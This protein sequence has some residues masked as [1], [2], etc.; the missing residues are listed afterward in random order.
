MNEQRGVKVA[1]R[2]LPVAKYRVSGDSCAAT[3]VQFR[4]Q[5]Q[6]IRTVVKSGIGSHVPVTSCAET[7]LYRM[8]VTT[9]KQHHETFS[10]LRYTFLHFIS[11]IRLDK[12]CGTTVSPIDKGLTITRTAWQNLYFK[13]QTSIVGLSGITLQISQL[14]FN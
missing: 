8:T 2:G 7:S 10:P 11:A 4:L 3:T 6:N 14:D 9:T 13:E 5:K 1:F 12:K